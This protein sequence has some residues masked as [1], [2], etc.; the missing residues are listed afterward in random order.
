MLRRLKFALI[1]VPLLVIGSFAIAACG[2]DDE[3]SSA[4]APTPAPTRPAATTAPAAASPTA[5]A[6]ANPTAASGGAGN[7]VAIAD[8]SFSPARLNAR[9][10]QALQ[11]TVSNAGQSQHTFTI[12]GVVDSGTIN[13]GQTRSVTFTPAT[14]G[15]LTFFCMIHG[16]TAM[17]GQI[18]VA[19]TSG[20]LPPPDAPSGQPMG[21]SSS[22]SGGSSDSAGSSSGTTGGYDYNY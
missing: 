11:L 17:S 10:G 4:A 16:Q 19:G 5:A 8:Y 9:A 3:D 15:T 18:T 14:A 1:L 6:A 13:P 22:S 2:G 7:S 21:G 12:T 20:S